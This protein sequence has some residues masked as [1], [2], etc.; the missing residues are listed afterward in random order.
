MARLILRC[1]HCDFQP[2]RV[3]PHLI[4]CP[5]LSCHQGTLQDIAKPAKPTPFILR[6]TSCGK[7]TISKTAATFSHPCHECGGFLSNGRTT[8]RIPRKSFS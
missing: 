8:R 5:C 1:S 4:G 7:L 2:A 6:C 3:H